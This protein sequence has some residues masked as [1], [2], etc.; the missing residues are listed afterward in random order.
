[1]NKFTVFALVC[2]FGLGACQALSTPTNAAS[3]VDIAGT[4]DSIAKTAIAQTL[5]AQP[6]PTTVPVQNTSTP[7]LAE[8]F[9]TSAPINTDTPQAN[10]TTTPATATNIPGITATVTPTI[11]LAGGS[12]TLTP[13][14]GVL[15]YG[16]LPPANKP[17]V[18]IT[19]VNKSKSQAYISLQVV[20][21]QGYTIIEYP[22]QRT[23]SIKIPTG[24]YTYVAWVGGRQFTGYF[25]VS[26]N[27]EPIITLYRDKVTITE[28]SI[29]YP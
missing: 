4:V 24:S 29:S 12:P 1:M 17:F 28:G 23:V 14:L 2:V 20:T 25:D 13:T 11:V 19:L 16:T 27:D 10:L 9:A 6:S 26:K 8:A 22:V 5:T 3:A 15:T 21:D 18:G 7:P